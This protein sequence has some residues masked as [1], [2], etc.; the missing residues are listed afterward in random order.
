VFWQRSVF[1]VGISYEHYNAAYATARQLGQDLRQ[2]LP[3]L[4]NPRPN[5]DQ[6]YPALN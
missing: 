3:G 1:R 2:Q 4:N 6:F 5:A